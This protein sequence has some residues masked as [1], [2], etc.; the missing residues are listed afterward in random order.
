MQEAAHTQEGE[1]IMPTWLALANAT[2]VRTLN[3][4]YPGAS[5]IPEEDEP[6]TEQE[7]ALGLRLFRQGTGKLG[8]KD[9]ASGRVGSGLS[10]DDALADLRG[11]MKTP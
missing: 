1:S 3:E 2:I 7:R 11:H 10:A 9:L 8:A 4:A 5:Y 6:Y